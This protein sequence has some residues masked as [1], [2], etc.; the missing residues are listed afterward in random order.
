MCLFQNVV[1]YKWHLMLK[2]EIASSSCLQQ[3]KYVPLII[4]MYIMIYQGI[5]ASWF[6]L[7]YLIPKCDIHMCYLNGQVSKWQAVEVSRKEN[8]V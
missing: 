3:A 7:N 6:G 5:I 4:N 8:L 1:V 2:F